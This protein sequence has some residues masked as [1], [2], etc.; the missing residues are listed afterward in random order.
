MTSA[1]P[2]ISSAVSPLHLK[3]HEE[4]GRPRF[5][6]AAVHYLAESRGR[7]R[8]GQVVS[9]SQALQ[10]GAEQTLLSGRPL[11]GPRLSG[12]RDAR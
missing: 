3:P 10:N 7:F 2:A 4:G 1:K 12:R 11:S 6:G 5:S 8:P 9:L